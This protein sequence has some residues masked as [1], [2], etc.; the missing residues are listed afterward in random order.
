VLPDYITED[1]AAG[2]RLK[3]YIE[4][5][6]ILDVPK[7]LYEQAEAA[8]NEMDLPYTGV[9]DFIEEQMKR[10]HEQHEQWKIQKEETEKEN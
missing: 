5:I 10:L 4:N 3:S 2:W 9:S 1:E 7:D 6:E 8:I